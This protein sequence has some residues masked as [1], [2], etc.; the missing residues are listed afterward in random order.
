M[1]ADVKSVPP[2]KLALIEKRRKQEEDDRQRRKEEEERLTQ[3]PSWKRD[4]LLK[5]QQQKNSLVFFAKPSSQPLENVEGSPQNHDGVVHHSVGL[6]VSVNSENHVEQVPVGNHFDV[7]D[8]GLAL[9][10]DDSGLDPVP[11]R[12]GPSEEHIIPI[13]QN[14]WLKTEIKQGRYHPRQHSSS[15]RPGSGSDSESLSH[16]YNSLPRNIGSTAS[17]HQVEPID[18]H[19]ETDEGGDEIFN[20]EE[21]EVAYGRGFVHKLL[22]KFKH[23]STREEKAPSATTGPKRSHSTENILE[24]SHGSGKGSPRHYSAAE[25]TGDGSRPSGIYASPAKA[26]S[27]EN[28][29][30][31]GGGN[32]HSYSNLEVKIVSERRDSSQGS[33]DGSFSSGSMQSPR[34]TSDVVTCNHLGEEEPSSHNLSHDSETL[35]D[36]EGPPSLKRYGSSENLIEAELPRANIVSNTRS[37]FENVTG[38]LTI[39]KTRRKAPSPKVEQAEFKYSESS[40]PNG[41]VSKQEELLRGR[42]AYGGSS[43]SSGVGGES[44]DGVSPRQRSVQQMNG[45]KAGNDRNANYKSDTSGVF[46]TESRTGIGPTAVAR[47]KPGDQG[48]VNGTWPSSSVSLESNNTKVSS[49]S[50]MQKNNQNNNRLSSTSTTTSSSSLSSSNLPAKSSSEIISPDQGS[51]KLEYNLANS[52]SKKRQA[53]LP[54]SS[55]A[56]GSQPHVSVVQVQNND[57]AGSAQPKKPNLYLDLG[58]ESRASKPA[59]PEEVLSYRDRYFPRKTLS[60]SSSSS[61]STVTKVTPSGGE[62]QKDLINT[63]IS[64]TQRNGVLESTTTITSS[65]YS[66]SSVP[67][68]KAPE[69]ERPKPQTLSS[70]SSSV[71]PKAKPVSYSTTTTKTSSSSSYPAKPVSKPVVSPTAPV[72]SS[73]KTTTARV[74]PQQPLP[75]NKPANG[76]AASLTLPIPKAGEVTLNNKTVGAKKGKRPPSSSGSKGSLLIR[77]ASNLVPTSANPNAQLPSIKKYQDVKSGVF[78]PPSANPTYLEGLEDEFDIPVTNIDDVMDDVP[79]TNLDDLGDMISSSGSPRLEQDADKERKMLSSKYDFI[80]AGV[81]TSKNLLIKTRAQKVGHSRAAHSCVRSVI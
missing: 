74:A 75:S 50:I 38:T 52:S 80:G 71:A 26:R 20:S 49:H 31:G 59:A 21:Q 42:D 69:P 56:G 4:I 6:E 65:S 57:E 78:Q 48:P 72:S 68:P 79:V 47:S 23:L 22:E 34:S 54:P 76:H 60:P 2:W 39:N 3:M 62:S 53:P 10:A 1:S 63:D 15:G 17:C 51:N 43:Q 36:G 28:L 70:S 66:S 11:V 37:L 44:G 58:S 8:D 67:A 18:V 64:G 46:N 73:V 24:D 35:V 45:S 27:M 16:S 9:P 19:N 13:Q 5:K 40:L 41:S 77:P 55:I 61:S 32:K 33:L 14:P 81:K 29:A 12:G 7:T 30:G 25:I